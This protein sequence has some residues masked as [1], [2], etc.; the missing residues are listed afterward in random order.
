MQQTK[1]KNPVNNQA[2]LN[3]R[4]GQNAN[5]LAKNRPLVGKQQLSSF[6]NEMAIVKQ[7]NAAAREPGM[8]A[9]VQEDVIQ[10]ETKEQKPTVNLE[11]QVVDSKLSEEMRGKLKE[12]RDKEVTKEQNTAQSF[13]EAARSSEELGSK[14]RTSELQASNVAQA[15]EKQ[16]TEAMQQG[17]VD[18]DGQQ[19]QNADDRKTQLDNWDD[20]APRITEDAMNQ[21]VRI[22]IPGLSDIET[23]IVR[24]NGGKVSIQAVG[25]GKTMSSLQSQAAVL[26]GILAKHNVAMDSLQAFD[27][28]QVGIR[29]GARRA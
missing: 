12:L 7:E 22:D 2:N 18:P 27:K 24:M 14:H 16:I 13:E 4:N 8:Q 9:L 5:G 6:A 23:L 25:N 1:I 3:I 11:T 28:S 20:L 21:A 26:S 15:N 19:H 10:K 29:G 17:N